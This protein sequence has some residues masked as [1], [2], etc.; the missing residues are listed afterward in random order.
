MQSLVQQIVTEY[1]LCVGHTGIRDMV[2]NR[3]D[4]TSCSQTADPLLGEDR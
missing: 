1:Q 3:T 2:V 4:E